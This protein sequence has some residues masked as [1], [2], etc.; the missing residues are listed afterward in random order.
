M[1]TVPTLDVFLKSDLGRTSSEGFGTRISPLL[2]RLKVVPTDHRFGTWV[3]LRRGV[4]D[5]PDRRTLLCLTSRP[6]RDRRPTEYGPV[7]WILVLTREGLPP[8]TQEPYEVRDRLLILPRQ[9]HPQVDPV[10]LWG[11][12][13]RRVSLVNG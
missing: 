12:H 9:S 3:S 1:S 5:F 7:Q 6:S 11:F 10:S 4:H 13:D 8:G 2:V